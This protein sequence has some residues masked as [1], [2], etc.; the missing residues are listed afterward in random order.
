MIQKR[1]EK[2][3]GSVGPID[4][5]SYLWYSSKAWSRLRERGREYQRLL[6]ATKTEK[7]LQIIVILLFKLIIGVTL[8]KFSASS[9]L[10]FISLD[11]G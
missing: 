6:R 7:I 8:A 1:E 2:R 4:Q 9:T 5:L 3:M 10:P 11:S